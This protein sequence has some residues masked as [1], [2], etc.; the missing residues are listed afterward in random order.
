MRGKRD[1]EDIPRFNPYQFICKSCLKKI[2]D[3]RAE[4]EKFM[5]RRWRKKKRAEYKRLGLCQH[6]GK[7]KEQEKKTCCNSCLQDRRDY[8]TYK[9]RPTHAKK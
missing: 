5:Q 7:P 6:C 3:A 1:K 8:Q 9:W 2:S 4:R